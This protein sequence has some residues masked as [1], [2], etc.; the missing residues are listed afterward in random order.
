MARITADDIVTQLT[1]APDE[2]AALA[3]ANGVRSRAMLDE[4]ADL[5]Y[6]DPY[7]RSSAVVRRAIAAGARH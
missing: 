6:V 3:V 4:V 1:Q 2:A 5:L 7:G